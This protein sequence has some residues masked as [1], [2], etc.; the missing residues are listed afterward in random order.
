MSAALLLTVTG[1]AL[2]DSLNP[3]TILGVG[4]ILVLA[5]RSPVPSALAYVLGAY[6]TVLG[7]GLALYLAADAAAGVVEGGL[8]WVRRI[9]FGLAALLLLR[10]AVARLRPS[11]RRAVA[12]PAWFSPWTALP[13]GVVVTGADLPNAFPYAIAIERMVSAGVEPPAG[14]LVLAAYSFVYCLPCLV[15]LV[16][17]VVW[18]ERVR[19]RLV[20]L[21]AR[22]G[23]ARE[24]PRSVPTALG[25]GVL[26]A[27]VA[28]IAVTA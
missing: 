4:L 20:G 15:L 22:F 28:G 1:L 24:L 19:A 3:A 12:L 17:G 21:H 13:L 25:L 23:R 27:A 6:A 7:L 16:A 5:S 11:R 18:G 10:A 8:V 14:V 26:A 2:V 9:A